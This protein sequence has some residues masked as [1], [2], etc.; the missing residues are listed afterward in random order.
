MFLRILIFCFTSVLFLKNINSQPFLKTYVVNSIVDENTFKTEKPDTTV[1]PLLKNVKENMPQ[2]YWENHPDVINCYWKAWDIAFSNLKSVNRVNGFV[3]PYI[4]P[5][6]NN[7]IF[8]WDCSFMTM[9]GKYARQV[10]NFQN[11]LNNFYSKQH[12]DGFICREIREIDGTDVFERFDPA[13]TGPNIMP[14]SEWEYFLNFNDIERLKK[15]FPVLLAYYDWYSTYRTWPDGSYYSSGWGCG[16]DNQKRVPSGYNPAFSHG[17]M[18][19]ID[20]SFQE[21]FSA[22][23]LIE[24]AKIISRDK[25]VE[26]IISQ[27]KMLI[28]YIN[29]NMWDESEKYYF[30]RN[31]NGLL[32]K[33][34]SIGSYWG[35]LAGSIPHD[36]VNQMVLHLEDTSMFARKHR[37]PTLSADDPFYD[38]N[39]DYWNGSIWAPTTYMVLRGL[40]KYNFDSLAFKI[41]INHLNN[42]VEVFNKTK[43]FWENYAP[44]KVQGNDRSNFVGWTGLVPIN[45]LFEYVFG[46]RA[47]VPENELTIDVNL[48]DEYGIINYPF[49]SNGKINIV[50][51]KRKNTSQ[52]PDVLITTN[53]PLKVVLKWSGGNLKSNIKVGQSSL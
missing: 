23:I 24:M 46:I 31:R 15:I 9:F 16:M 35:L 43:T 51:K 34:K 39:G 11:T 19:W 21:V 33:T 5:A 18:S 25:D 12:P 7:N 53:L 49:G 50:C 2:P 42:V 29:K 36:R 40:T 10:F 14:W 6:F 27:K 41:G 38:P 28:D 47:N 37:I 45:V 22:N 20:I 1:P 17:F 48:L 4:D 26:H 44:D 32:N 13:S 52:K 30:D 8:M 3:S